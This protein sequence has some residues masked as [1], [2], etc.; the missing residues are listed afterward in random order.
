MRLS[1][2]RCL[3]RRIFLRRFFITLPIYDLGK[4]LY[5]TKTL[6]YPMIRPSA[7]ENARCP[8][9]GDNGS[10]EGA[11][12]ATACGPS[13]WLA[14]P[15]RGP[16]LAGAPRIHQDVGGLSNYGYLAGENFQKTAKMEKLGLCW[17]L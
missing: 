2:L 4:K 1:S 8:G 5:G 11:A 15:R 12:I 6:L 13:P 14:Q 3:W 10:G 7:R 17:V 9:L 16:G